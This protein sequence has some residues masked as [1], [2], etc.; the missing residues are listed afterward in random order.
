[1]AGG[2]LTPRQKMINMMYLVLTALLALN[3]TKEVINAFVTINESVTLSKNNVIKK[4][5]NTYAAF[6]Q[7]MSVDAVKYKD[8]NE[9]ANKVRKEADDVAK[10]IEDLKTE[11]IRKVD[12]IK[13]GEPT[14]ALADMEAKD[15]YDVPT[16]ILCGDGQDGRG[17]KAT[18]LKKRLEAYK[19]VV[20]ANLPESS[21][22]NFEKTISEL[23]KTEDPVKVGDD[24]KRTWEMISFYHNPVVASVT[25]LTKFQNDVRTAESQVIDELLTSVDKNIIKLDKL[26]AKVIANSTVVTIGSDFQADVFLSA[27]SSTM[28]PEVF[29]GATYDSVKNEMKGGSDKPL[30][31]EGGYA[32]YT[33]RPGSEGEKKWGGVIRVKKPDGT[34]DH[35][36]FQSS[37]IAQKPNSVVSADKMNVLYIGVDNPMSISVPGVSND[38]VKASIEGSGGSL[39]PNPG[40][41]GGHYIATVSTTGKATIKV[42]AEIGGKVMPMGSFEYR[43]KRVPDPVAKIA[44]NK[45]GPINKNLLMAGTLIPELENF[46]FELFFKIISF[47]MT[48]TGKGKDLQEFETQG[49]QLSQAMRDALSKARAGDKVFFE[50]I[51]AKMATGADQSTRNLSPMAFQIQ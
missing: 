19:K 1:M 31:V 11:L 34:Y 42:A 28:A 47:K 49:N 25:L 36:P 18:E 21:K 2:K 9:R 4:N 17:A 44:N 30:P 39:K 6:E 20:L 12:N 33:D 23:L 7:A 10:F 24:K 40:A 41:G 22:A 3:V 14:P 27:T 50:Y 51:K 38:K 45:G 32:K 43:V 48:I 16:Y 5:Q 46:D 37:Y 29:I 15:N 26:N 8:V 13:D 35:F